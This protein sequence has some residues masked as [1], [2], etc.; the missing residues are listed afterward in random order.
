VKTVVK[1]HEQTRDQLHDWVESLPGRDPERRGLAQLV[2]DEVTRLLTET[3]GSPPNTRRIAGGDP[4]RY[5]LRVTNTLW[6]Q[7]M[8]REDAKTWLTLFRP[9]TNR[10]T[11]LE[12]RSVAPGE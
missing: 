11:T 2:L 8:V 10:V 3:S 12:L 1:W 7:Y 6:V 4:A 9:R 5:W